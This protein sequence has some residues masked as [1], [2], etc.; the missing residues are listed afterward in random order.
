MVLGVL[1]ALATSVSWTTANVFIQR[2]SRAV[3]PARSMLWALASGGLLSAVCAAIFDLR[4][5]PVTPAVVAWVAVAA[6]AGLVAY[7]GLF[8][9][10]AHAQLSVAVPLVSSWSLFAVLFARVAWGEAARVSHAA[11][12]VAVFV[13]IVLVSVD[14]ARRTE[15]SQSPEVTRGGRTS[16][17]RAAVAAL[18]SGMGFGVMVPAMGRIAPAA[19]AFGATAVVYAAGLALAVPLAW[20]MG[21]DCRP[22]PR[23]RWPV[24][25]ASGACETAGFVTLALAGRHA[26]TVVVAPAASLGSTM[27]VLYAWAVLREHP[28]TLARCGAALA[29]GGVVLLAVGG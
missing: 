27:T 21:A 9:A 14:D 3:G 2:S 19:G 8:Y 6:A 10:F 17:R 7:G 25:L 24:V 5:A 20:V 22:P 23:S 26:P 4:R 1:L 11:G 29:C 16:R 18:A 12:A 13:G 28:G 15:A